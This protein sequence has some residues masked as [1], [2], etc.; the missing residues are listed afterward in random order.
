MWSRSGGATEL[1]VRRFTTGF[2]GLLP[3]TSSTDYVAEVYRARVRGWWGRT[4]PEEHALLEVFGVLT[5]HAALPPPDP[6]DHLDERRLVCPR[7]DREPK[8]T[9]HHCLSVRS[10]SRLR[11]MPGTRSAILMGVLLIQFVR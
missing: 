1:A 10:A 11:E 4:D 8:E 2:L 7:L 3:A 5:G 6:E 9:R